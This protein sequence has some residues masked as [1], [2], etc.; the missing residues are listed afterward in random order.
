MDGERDLYDCTLT[1]ILLS[2]YVEEL[3]RDA[4]V[5]K[6]AELMDVLRTLPGNEAPEKDV[7]SRALSEVAAEINVDL[8][9]INKMLS[10]PTAD[11]CGLGPSSEIAATLLSGMS[12][13][14]NA[15]AEENVF[16][17]AEEA[18]NLNKKFREL[19]YATGMQGM[20]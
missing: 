9:N 12:R 7:S 14:E 1:G 13:L 5:M 16:G 20:R 8:E 15:I 17:M 18:T 10:S 3:N 4:S 2:G 11:K 19:V 6:F